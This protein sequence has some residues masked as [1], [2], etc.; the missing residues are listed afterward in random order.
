MLLGS[1]FLCGKSTNTT[2]GV[3]SMQEQNRN[4]NNQNKQNDQNNNKNNNKAQTK[5]E[6]NKSQRS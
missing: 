3:T 4:Q 6:Q 2:K 5:P 1:N